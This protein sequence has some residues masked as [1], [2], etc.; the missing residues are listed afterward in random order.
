[1]NL[2]AEGEAAPSQRNQ[3]DGGAAVN[4][5]LAKPTKES[6]HIIHGCSD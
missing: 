1:M 5:G 2:P 3:R 6:V 4:W